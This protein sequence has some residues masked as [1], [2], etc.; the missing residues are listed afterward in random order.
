MITLVN[1]KDLFARLFSPRYWRLQK[2]L[3]I[4]QR[5]K[6]YLTREEDREAWNALRGLQ[7]KLLEEYHSTSSTNEAQRNDIHVR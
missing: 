1:I 5:A 6:N 4:L 3:V 2:G 7:R